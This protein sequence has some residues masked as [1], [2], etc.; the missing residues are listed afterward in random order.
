[1][2]NNIKAAG[3]V[4]IASMLGSVPSENGFYHHRKISKEER[5]ERDAIRAERKKERQRRKKN[6]NR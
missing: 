2:T 3:I 4:A 5:K 1:M 6:R